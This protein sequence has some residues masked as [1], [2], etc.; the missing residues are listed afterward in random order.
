MKNYRR[1]GHSKDHN[2]LYSVMLQCKLTEGT[3]DAF[4]RDVK[5][6]PDPQCV[7]MFDFQLQDLVRFLTDSKKFSI[8]T[9]DMTYNVGNFYVMPTTYKHLMLVDTMSKKHP[10]MAGPILVH[11]RKNFAAFN[12]FASTLICFNKKLQQI[13][14]FGTDGDVA[15]V[16]AFTHNFPFAMQLQFT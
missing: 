14:A 4:V 9:A 5:A 11:Q 1:T 6:A 7:M 15:L 13:Q 16:E 12:Y 2:V 3:S 8:F 10:T